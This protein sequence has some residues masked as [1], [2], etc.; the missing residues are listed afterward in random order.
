MY[1]MEAVCRFV[2]EMSATIT[3][4][5][6]LSSLS[7]GN[8]RAFDLVFKQLYPKLKHFLVRLCGDE[9]DAENL[10]QDIFMRLWIK[11]KQLSEIDNLDAYVYSMAKN[12]GLALIKMSLRQESVPLE[13]TAQLSEG[14]S[15]EDT[16][17]YKELKDLIEKE[18]G[19]MPRQRRVIFEMSRSEGLSNA[20]IAQRLGI[21]KRTVESHISLALSD[22][23][24]IMPLLTI[25]SLLMIEK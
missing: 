20:E 8:E 6:L 10:V 19:N 15:Q 9:D 14:A 13:A 1:M 5:L 4:E 12:A 17:Y 22:L 16:L 7:Q 2:K 25:L 3:D 21:S 23:R 11:R 18:I 24:R